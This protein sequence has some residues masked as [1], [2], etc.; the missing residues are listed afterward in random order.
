MTDV[1]NAGWQLKELKIELA[2]WGEFKG[3]YIG[4][5]KFESG[6]TDA[7]MFTLS[8]DEMK[9]YLAIISAKVGKSASEL[10]DKITSSLKA[11]GFDERPIIHL[12]EK[13]ED[14]LPFD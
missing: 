14:S 8:P 9:D 11:L 3:K 4:K 13:G 5:I 7:F 6:N 2:E 12:T 10:G 1:L